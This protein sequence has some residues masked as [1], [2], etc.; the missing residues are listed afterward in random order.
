MSKYQGDYGYQAFRILQLTF[1]IAPILAGL[2]KFFYFLT[3]WSIY[4][5]PT[6]LEAIKGYGKPF[7]YAVGVIEII[8]GIGMIF[9]PKFF[10]YVASLW[11]LLIVINLIF[12]GRYWDI[13]L[14]D[15]GLCLAALALG[16]ISHKYTT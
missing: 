5:S 10:A 15:L 16:R 2:D 14:R 6:A 8:V 13:A 3:D 12:L 11:L 1:I 9:K 4:L 7:L